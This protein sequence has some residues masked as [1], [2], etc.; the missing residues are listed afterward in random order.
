V[1]CQQPAQLLLLLLQLPGPR[2]VL[3]GVLLLSLRQQ[4]QHLHPARSK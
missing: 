1:A 3:L 4:M 2:A